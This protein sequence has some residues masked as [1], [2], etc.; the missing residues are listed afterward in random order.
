LGEGIADGGCHAA[1]FVVDAATSA[2]AATAKLTSFVWWDLAVAVDA[3]DSTTGHAEE[4]SSGC[5]SSLLPRADV[6][7]DAAAAAE[8]G[9]E[10]RSSGCAPPP[11]ADVSADAAAAVGEREEDKECGSGN[12]P[13]LPPRADVGADAHAAAE[14]GEEERGS[15]CA[16]PSLLHADVGLDAA[17]AEEAEEDEERGSGCVP[18]PPPHADVGADTAAATVEGE[19]DE[20]L[21]EVDEFSGRIAAVR[22]WEE[23]QHRAQRRSV[24]L[25]EKKCQELE[26]QLGA[27][28]Q[29]EVVLWRELFGGGAAACSDAADADVHADALLTEEAVLLAP[30]ASPAPAAH[31]RLYRRGRGTSVQLGANNPLAHEE[32][33]AAR[34][35]PML[36]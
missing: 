8:G 29:A 3:E 15:G 32:C 25:L 21:H 26:Q 31:E 10:E 20:A 22:T 19:K 35:V 5:V 9:E 12:A 13:P 27:T 24:E 11:R 34:A 7:A 16:P 36:R 33:T 14:E 4:R 30:L 2:S 1:G 18:P 17:A 28:K 23:S 6:G